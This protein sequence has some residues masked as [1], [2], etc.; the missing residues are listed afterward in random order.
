[1]RLDRMNSNEGWVKNRNV[2]VG[3][4]KK[5]QQLIGATARSKQTSIKKKAFRIWG[6]D[7]GSCQFPL[8][9]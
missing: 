9:P 4:K 3:T 6:Q 1:M 8:F 2:K 7:Q 5:R